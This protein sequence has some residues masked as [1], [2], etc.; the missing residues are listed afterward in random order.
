MNNIKTHSRKEATVIFGGT[1]DPI[2]YGHLRSA[3]ELYEVL[4]VVDFRLLPAGQPVHRRTPES[5]AE[6]RL[7]ML[8]LALESHHDLI[9]DDR[10]ITRDGPSYMVET[11]KEL[12]AELP[13]HHT[14][15]LV[16]GQ[17]AANYLDTWHDW[18]S[19]F[20]L[21]HLI[22]MT[23]PESVENYQGELQQL[24]LENK[25]DLDSIR[26]STYGKVVHLPV[27]QLAISST[28][29]RAQLKCGKNPRFLLPDEVLGYIKDNSLYQLI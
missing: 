11:L 4:G 5:T 24:M 1:F 18:R 13:L 2:H 19:L 7:A 21:T 12:R 3:A 15:M 8:N 25:G 16:V 9:V 29:I 20:S 28:D 6:Q 17:D 23:R 27:T 22:V 10:E 14:L 26:L